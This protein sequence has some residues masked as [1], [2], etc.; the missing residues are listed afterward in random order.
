MAKGLS[1]NRV[2]EKEGVIGRS[3][4]TM[5]QKALCKPGCFTYGFLDLLFL[6]DISISSNISQMPEILVHFIFCW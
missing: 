4:K 1:G 6:T 3:T 2:W 5:S